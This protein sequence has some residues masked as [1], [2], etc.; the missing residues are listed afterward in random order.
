MDNL[1]TWAFWIAA[2][3]VGVA[4]GLAILCAPAIGRLL[5]R[6]LWPRPE[7]TPEPEP[8]PRH[9]EPASAPG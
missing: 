5:H 4:Q 8:E 3:A 6:L 1:P 9:Q 7:V 2:G